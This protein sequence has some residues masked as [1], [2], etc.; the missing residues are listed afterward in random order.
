MVKEVM[1]AQRMRQDQT[2]AGAPST[3]QVTAGATQG[4]PVLTASLTEGQ[5]HPHQRL[6]R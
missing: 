5:F 1:D 6:L 4:R 3:P 2:M